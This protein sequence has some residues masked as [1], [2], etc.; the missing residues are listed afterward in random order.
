[1]ARYHITA[2]NYMTVGTRR[3][4]FNIDTKLAYEV[5]NSIKVLSNELREENSIGDIREES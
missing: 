1:M 3:A 2:L 4:F 5:P